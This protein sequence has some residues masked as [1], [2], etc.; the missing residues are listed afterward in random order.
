MGLGDDSL[1]F[2]YVTVSSQ[3]EA[4]KIARAL[5]EE[6]LVACVNILPGMRSIYRWADEG[7]E[8]RIDSADEIVLIAKTR[9]VLFE[10]V[11]ER[12]LALHSYQC[13]CIVGLPVAAA[14]PAFATW[15][16]SETG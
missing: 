4:D 3:A 12:I 15:L 14:S 10:K 16:A 8:S 6:R 11:Q 7:G 2:V 1:I 5:V 13:P 9:I